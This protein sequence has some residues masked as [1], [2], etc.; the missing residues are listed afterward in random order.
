VISTWLCA[1]A[2]VAIYSDSSGLVRQ[3]AVTAE[4]SLLLW[5]SR[6]FPTFCSVLQLPI[7]NLSSSQYGSSIILPVWLMEMFQYR[8]MRIRRSVT[9]GLIAGLSV[10][11]IFRNGASLNFFVFLS[12]LYRASSI[13]LQINVSNRCNWFYLYFLYFLSPY[14][15]RVFTGPSSG[16][17]LAVIMLPFGFYVNN[18]ITLLVVKICRDGA[19]LKFFVFLSFLYRA[20]S[21]DLQIKV[22]R[23][24]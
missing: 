13:D 1:S 24:F 4:V 10:V 12:F 23:T 17:S 20:Y 22:S 8:C 5:S 16:V 11:K 6:H 2:R 14:M 18:K 3:V 21:I 15:F 7:D 19:S 9:S